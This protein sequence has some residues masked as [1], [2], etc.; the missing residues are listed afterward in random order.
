MLTDA[1]C[2]RKS[3]HTHPTMLG[4]VCDYIEIYVHLQFLSASQ[5]PTSIATQQ[6][7]S[8]GCAAA[9][10]ISLTLLLASALPT[11]PRS[12]TCWLFFILVFVRQNFTCI[13]ALV[14][15]LFPSLHLSISSSVCI[16]LVRPARWY[17]LHM[18]SP[19]RPCRR[20]L[21]RED[22]QLRWPLAAGFYLLNGRT[23]DGSARRMKCCGVVDLASNA[24]KR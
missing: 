22:Y 18:C 21:G 5:D 3:T 8:L 23:F 16:A 2:K 17:I 7:L 13:F 20:P 24:S 15:H 11:I 10:L 6:L 9:V 1:Q 14:F 12:H 19:A 4:I